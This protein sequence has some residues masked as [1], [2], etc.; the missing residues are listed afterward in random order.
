MMG[1]ER[2]IGRRTLLGSAV[3]ALAAPGAVRAQQAERVRRIGV[4]MTAAERDPRVRL[5]LVAFERE[6]RRHG[7]VQGRNVR[8]DYRWAT[9]EPE[10]IRR[11]AEE[12]VA[13][14]LDL[15]IAQNTPATASLLRYTRTVP[16]VFFQA[17]DPPGSGFISSLAR[18]GGN[19]TGFIDLEASLAGKWL[20]LLKEVA[21]RIARAAMLYNPS[22]ATYA[23]YYLNVFKAA[24]S[25]LGLEAIEAPVRDRAGIASAI[26]AQAR[27]PNGG[28]IVTPEAFTGVH[29]AEIVAQVTRHRLPTVYP[30]RHFVELG[31]L[32][33]YGIDLV[34]HYG[35][36]AAHADRILRGEKP[37]EIPVEQPTRFEL[38]INLETAKT[39][40]L[41]VAMSLLVRADAVIE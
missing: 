1:G 21:P 20:D 9:T 23:S 13:M 25:S 11:S 4:L 41:E 6:L 35:R 30:Y 26:A 16:I 8:I 36:A 15:L 39:L 38:V 12:L 2:M 14:Q 22:T 32:L 24:A 27:T 34:H 5:R 28:V 17:S 3:L 7:W 31:G 37:G 40:G 29:R 33:S 10:R 18:P 19:A